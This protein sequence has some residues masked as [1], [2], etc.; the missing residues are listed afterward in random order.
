MQA[1]QDSLPSE[2]PHRQAPKPQQTQGAGVPEHGCQQHHQDRE[3]PAVRIAVPTGPD[4][5]LCG[6]G[7]SPQ[8][9][10]PTG[11]LPSRRPL[12]PRQS[13]RRLARVPPLRHRDPP[14]AEAARR[15]GHH[16]DRED[17][18]KPG[19]RWTLRAPAGGARGR[20]HRS[21]QGGRGRG[22]RAPRRRH[23][24]G[25]IP[26]RQRGDDPPVVPRG[27]DPRASGGGEAADRGR[28]EEEVQH[29]EGVRDGVQ[30]QASAAGRLPRDK[31]RRQDMAEERGGLRLGAEG[32]G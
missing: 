12:P 20:R 5:Q 16:P 18:R 21:R 4:G 28:G 30:H 22:R 15:P 7:G 24:R 29:E 10:Q 13:V 19:V 8:H 31:G 27:Q 9:S 25:R 14:A 11:Q 26:G 3:P 17:P 23:P 2:Q 32:I 1:P 6:Q